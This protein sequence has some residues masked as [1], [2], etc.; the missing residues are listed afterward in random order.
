M[1]I[2]ELVRLRRTPTDFLNSDELYHSWQKSVK[3]LFRRTGLCAINLLE[4]VWKAL[5]ELP[6]FLQVKVQ[7][8]RLIGFCAVLLLGQSRI[9]QVD[10]TGFGIKF[11]SVND[12]FFRSYPASSKKTDEKNPLRQ[13][14]NFMELNSFLNS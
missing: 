12:Q 13:V 14:E 1:K 2:T 4:K 9:K 7:G 5:L 3:I 8:Y 6:C 10:K 11:Q